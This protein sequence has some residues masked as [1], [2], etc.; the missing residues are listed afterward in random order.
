MASL[1]RV[2]PTTAPINVETIGQPLQIFTI[3][4]INAVNAGNGPEGVQ[5]LVQNAIMA[6]ATIVVNGNSN[7]EQ[8]FVTE[9]S[10]S[11]VVGTLQT[12][13]R[14]LGTTAGDTSV[15]VSTATVTAKTF[16]VAV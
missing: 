15:D 12:A 11:I 9:G 4:Y 5:A 10:D 3:D 16:T 13:I 7:T 1:T 2:H 8:T 14:A 6:T